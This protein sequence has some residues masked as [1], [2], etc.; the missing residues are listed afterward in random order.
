MKNFKKPITLCLVAALLF[1]SVFSLSSCYIVDSGEMSEIEGSYML[2]RYSTDE[3]EIAANNISLY[4]MIKSD[5]TG[6]YAYSSDD[7]SLHYAGLR[8]RFTADTEEAGKYSYVEINFGSSDE[9]YK[10]GVNAGA[11]KL[12]YSK[13]K[14]KGNLFAGDLAIDYYIDV[15]FIRVDKRTTI[16]YMRAKLG[17]APILPYGGLRLDGSYFLNRVA[18]DSTGYESIPDPHPFVYIYL[19]IDLIAKTGKVWYMLSTDEIEVT[20]EFTVEIGEDS[21]GGYTIKLGDGEYTATA[22]GTYSQ[23]IRI[24]YPIGDYADAYIEF[25]CSGNK[26]EEEILADIDMAKLSYER[27]K[28]E[29]NLQP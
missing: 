6:Y 25:S 3:D 17:E 19:D 12:S 28:D 1:I 18:S 9:W 16:N 10:F 5:G 24:P 14:Y 26:T 11:E 8:C 7:V 29:E 21:D 23:Y 13:P 20:D 2:S 4:I 15:D 22:N 27:W